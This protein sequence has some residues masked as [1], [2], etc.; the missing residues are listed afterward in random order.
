MLPLKGVSH[1]PPT[2][3]K[4]MKASSPNLVDF[5][6]VGHKWVPLVQQLGRGISEWIPKM[7]SVLPTLFLCWRQSHGFRRFPLKAF[8]FLLETK[9]EQGVKEPKTHV[10]FAA[11]DV[12]AFAFSGPGGEAQALLGRPGSRPGRRRAPA[13]GKGPAGVLNTIP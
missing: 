12:E 11:S 10:T 5:F 13:R 8:S 1:C 2:H 3:K 7:V 9:T 4:L 6:G